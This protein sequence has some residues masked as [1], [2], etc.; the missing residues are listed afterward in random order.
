MTSML[1]PFS[2]VHPLIFSL[3]KKNYSIL[4]AP[5]P[6][7]CGVNI[8]KK[9]FEEEIQKKFKLDLEE[10]LLVFLD[11]SKKKLIFSMEFRAKLILPVFK[12]SILKLKNIYNSFYEK[13]GT[14]GQKS[15][16]VWTQDRTHGEL[17]SSSFREI[18]VER[19]V[20]ALP[21]TE[22]YVGSGEEVKKF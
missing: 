10:T 3:P 18:L 16:I 9:E 2:W 6:L 19:L 14:F 22:F 4:E 1:K 7:I 15:D 12:N 21:V 17:V 8:S 5:V 13:Y 20:Y 11:E